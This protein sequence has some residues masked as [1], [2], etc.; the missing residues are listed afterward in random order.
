[1]KK[2]DP[3]RVE[4]GTITADMPQDDYEKLMKSFFPCKR[5]LD[6]KPGQYTLRL[7]VLDRKA[8]LIGTL[9]TPLNVP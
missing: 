7:G 3:I 1:P 9:S 8:N 6:L 5:A 2:G 4:G